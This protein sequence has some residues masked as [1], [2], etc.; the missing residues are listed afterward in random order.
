[1]NEQRKLRRLHDLSAL[2]KRQE[3]LKA[4]GYANALRHVRTAQLEREQL[5]EWQRTLILESEVNAGDQID[6]AQQ[7]ARH[8]YERF[9][10]GRIVEQDAVIHELQEV[11]E[12]K[13]LDMQESVKQRRMMETLAEQ[14]RK[15]V[16]N[17]TKRLERLDADETASIRAALRRAALKAR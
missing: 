9:L 11:A 5:Q 13:R 8:N 3:N 16:D 6:A 2:R 10:A 14:S 15:S 12:E 7:R 17:E 4:Q 1:M